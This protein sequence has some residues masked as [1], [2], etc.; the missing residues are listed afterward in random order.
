MFD[1]GGKKASVGSPSRLGIGSWNLSFN[2][3]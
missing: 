2:Q 1:Q 3:R